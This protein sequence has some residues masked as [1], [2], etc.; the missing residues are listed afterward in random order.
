MKPLISPSHRWQELSLNISHDKVN[1]EFK[2]PSPVHIHLPC[3]NDLDESAAPCTPAPRLL[4]I[5]LRQRS[6]LRRD[7]SNGLPSLGLRTR[8]HEDAMSRSFRQLSRSD[9]A[10]AHPALGSRREQAWA[11][12]GGIGSG[13]VGQARLSDPVV[14]G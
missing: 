13:G 8:R 2:V 5:S 6:S 7:R 1:A 9:E 3:R 10:G 12:R 11:G 14:L 4:S